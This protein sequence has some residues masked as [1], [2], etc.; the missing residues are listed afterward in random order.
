MWPDLQPR[1][2]FVVKRVTRNGR[3][4]PFSIAQIFLRA[5]LDI[6]GQRGPAPG[7]KLVERAP[8]AAPALVQD[9]GIDHRRSDIAMAEQFLDRPD[10]V[11]AFQQMGCE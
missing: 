7:P 9:M 4:M 11:T 3:D 2:S 1:Q 10:V 6:C 8:D 5:F